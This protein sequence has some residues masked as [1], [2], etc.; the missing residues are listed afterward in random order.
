[1][2]RKA[3]QCSLW[4]SSMADKHQVLLDNNTWLLVPRPPRTNVVTDKWIYRHKFH[5]DGTLHSATLVYCDNVSVIY[6]SSN[7][8]QHRRTKHI[9]IEIHFVH[10][11]VSLG[12]VRV[13]HVPSSLQFVN[14]MTKGLLCQL[15]LEF[16]FS[17][18]VRE[19]PAKT[20]EG[21]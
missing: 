12:E 4:R 1:M 10:E 11:K 3:M 13:L 16:R 8:V 20:A 17:L 9:E 18:C 5:S 7:P 21:C 2:F 14:V 15:F 6:M 19:L